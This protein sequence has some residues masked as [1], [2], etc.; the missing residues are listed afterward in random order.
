[1]KQTKKAK[2][3]GEFSTNLGHDPHNPWP[4][5]QTRDTQGRFFSYRR[6]IHF[7]ILTI[8]A[9]V[10][11]L[12]LARWDRLNHPVELFNPLV[13][14][15]LGAEKTISQLVEEREQQTITQMIVDRFG[16]Y[17]DQ[18][19]RVAYC[20]SRL[21]RKAISHTHDYGVF[22]INKATWFHHYTLDNESALLA[23][24]NIAV[25]YDIFKNNGYSWKAWYSSRGCHGL[26]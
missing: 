5:K 22:Q 7:I 25:A 23:Y 19:V 4:L 6:L 20:E 26:R 8:A 15:S 17:A 11:I 14:D 21:N 24:E 18:A 13:S 12:A 3:I 16:E 9:T 2:W 1:M 10:L